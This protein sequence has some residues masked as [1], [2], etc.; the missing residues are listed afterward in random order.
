MSGRSNAPTIPNLGA[1]ESGKSPDAATVGP[2]RDL[3]QQRSARTDQFNRTDPNQG[4][5]E[6]D[7]W[8]AEEVGLD[9]LEGIARAHRARGHALRFLG[10]YVEAIQEYDLAKARF[11]ALRLM[12]EDFRTNLGYVWALRYLARYTE[13]ISLALETRSY[14]EDQNSPVLTATILVNLG[15]VYRRTGDLTLALD[16]YRSAERLSKDHGDLPGQARA[17]MNLGNLLADL[18]QFERSLRSLQHAGRIY[19]RLGQHSSVALAKMNIG[20]LHSQ[21]GE[22]GEAIA[23]LSESRDVYARLKLRRDRAFVDLYLLRAY[24]GLNLKREARQA[25]RRAIA[26]LSDLNMPYELGQALLFLASMLEADGKLAQAARQAKSAGKVFEGAGNRA[27]TAISRAQAATIQS[28]LRHGLSRAEAIRAITAAREELA[29]LGAREWVGQLWLCSGDLLALDGKLAEAR[30]AYLQGIDTGEAIRS[31]ELLYR[32]HWA[33]GLLPD[34]AANDALKHFRTAA[35]LVERLRLRTRATELK[36]SF[37]GDKTPL[38][39]AALAVLL[40]QPIPDLPQMFGFME[41][42]RS[43][44]LADAVSQSGQS[45]LQLPAEERRLTNRISELRAR[46]AALYD[47]AYGTTGEPAAGVDAQARK[48][49]DR[50]EARIAKAHQRLALVRPGADRSALATL[51]QLRGTLDASTAAITYFETRGALHALVMT[52]RGETLVREI[53]RVD[54]VRRLGRRVQFHLGKAAYGSDYLRQNILSLRAGLDDPLRA[55]WNLLIAPIASH[56]AQAR[57]LVVLPNAVTYGLPFHAFIDGDTYATERF[58]IQYAPSATMRC[59]N[60]RR[61]PA[62]SGPLLIVGISDPTV[63]GVRTEVDRLHA[64]VPGSVLLVDDQASAQSLRRLAPGASALHLAT[65][66]VFREDNPAFSGV[67]LA[68]GWLTTGDLAEI[69]RDMAMV[70]L[71]ACESAVGGDQGGGEIMGLSQAILGGGCRAL[72]SSLWTA[73]DQSTVALMS[74]FYTLLG[75]GLPASEAMRQAMLAARQRDDH[76]YFWAPFAV[77]GDMR[78]PL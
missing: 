61:P 25:C 68:D 13:A 27:W 76:P 63:P 5:R 75:R 38:Y 33:L 18:G 55:L 28:R 24:I 41:R 31:D 32:A 10:R 43:R 60:E 45:A 26:T 70:T 78:R 6:A 42:S 58:A 20:R 34:T 30:H 15:A 65:H 11:Q 73:D 8:L 19:Q 51:D 66:G 1:C 44:T 62:A 21:R 56:L 54:E 39:E 37:V 64:L 9:R 29:E 35:D 67:K 47:R 23:V 74:D 2:L 52:Q 40:D 22:F 72:V 14:Y 69:C 57:T 4:L 77:F 3:W 16:A 59:V 46:A 36:V 17:A 53:T 50:L 12:G 71:S 49:L 48:Q 7:A